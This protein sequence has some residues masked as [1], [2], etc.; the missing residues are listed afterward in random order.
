MLDPEIDLVFKRLRQG[1]TD[2]EVACAAIKQLVR[3]HVRQ[4][5]IAAFEFFADTL[6]RRY[7]GR[8]TAIILSELKTRIGQIRGV[9][10]ETLWLA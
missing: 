10:N 7:N 1:G 8:N 5:D 9:P 2:P 3:T 4:T 6:F